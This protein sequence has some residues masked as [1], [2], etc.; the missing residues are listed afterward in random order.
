M[1]YSDLIE[2]LLSYPNVHL[3]FLNPIEFSRGSILEEFF[4]Y[5]KIAES[6]F[7]LEHLSDILRI[8]LLSKYSGQYLDLDVFPL[9]PLSVINR[10]NFACPERKNLITNAVI[11]LDSTIGRR[12][13]S[14][15]LE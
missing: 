8:F 6:K 9:V 12:I 4:K 15:Y 3:R 5:D 2:A 13:A 1:E 7:P 11:N 10:E 14:L